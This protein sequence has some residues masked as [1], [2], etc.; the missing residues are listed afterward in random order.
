MAQKPAPKELGLMESVEL[1]WVLKK[2][3]R[4]P[5]GELSILFN[6]YH[7]Q[8]LFGCDKQVI[9]LRDDMN[10]KISRMAKRRGIP[11]LTKIQRA[12]ILKTNG[13]K[14]MPLNKCPS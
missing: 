7:C 9:I 6:D 3:K 4:H 8:I 2:L 10:E 1:E 13:T 14:Q 12:Q 5:Q 11:D